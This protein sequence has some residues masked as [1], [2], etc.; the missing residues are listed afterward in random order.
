M[1]TLPSEF[2]SIKDLVMDVLS[3]DIKSRDNDLH[4]YLQCCKSLGAKEL[5]DIEVIGL[6]FESVRRVRQK[7][8]N[9]DGKYI[10]SPQTSIM[11]KVKQKKI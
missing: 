8:Q 11:R 1:Q 2:G 6:N 4:L 7:I 5:N 3:E 9:E 10:P